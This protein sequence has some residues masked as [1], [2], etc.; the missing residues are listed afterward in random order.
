[1]THIIIKNLFNKTILAN[2]GTQTA[3]DVIHDNYIDW[4]HTC[5]KKGNCTTCKMIVLEGSENLS[6]LSANEN[7][8]RSLN[9][10]AANERLACQTEVRG[11]IVVEVPAIYKLP[12]I[13]YSY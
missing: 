8:F 3:L 7:R 5:G 6:P 2:N 9:R 13:K 12:H 4:M 1:M 11:D 10:L